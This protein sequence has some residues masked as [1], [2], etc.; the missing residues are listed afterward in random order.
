MKAMVVTSNDI[1]RQLRG[2]LGEK[3][4]SR[5][6]F[7]RHYPTYSISQFASVPPP[8]SASVTPF[9][10]FFISRIETNKGVYDILK[11]ALRLETDRKGSFH[12]DICGDG[13]ELIAL[14]RRISELKLEKVVSC[15]GYCTREKITRLIGASHAWIV[16]T[17]SDYEAGFEMV[18]AEAILSGRP[19][20]TSAVCPALED[21]REAAVEVQ[22]DNI[23][24]YCK[25]IVKLC[26]DP[27]Y[28]L[29]KYRACAALQEPFYNL[30]NSWTSKMKEALVNHIIR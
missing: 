9:N 20:I 8:P 13:G 11:I 6:D 2:L 24:E 23:D 25:A 4:S 7:V 15:H 29:D 3:D 22:P 14:R 26:D 18:C 12:F 10:V 30:K 16:P 28:Y 17:K 1:T 21:V 5:I 27:Q 19:L